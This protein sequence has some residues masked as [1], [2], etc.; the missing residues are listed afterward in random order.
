MSCPAVGECQALLGIPGFA[1]E[2]TGI[3][4]NCWTFCTP[5]V[6]AWLLLWIAGW[7]CGQCE[8]FGSAVPTTTDTSAR[9][10][11]DVSFLASDE[12][13]GRDA[14]IQGTIIDVAGIQVARDFLIQELQDMGAVGIDMSSTDP[15]SYLQVDTS[16]PLTNIIGV[17]VGSD[18]GGL[19]NEYV[20][21]G[22]HYD[23]LRFC[24][25]SAT[26]NS[27]V[28]NGATDNAAGVASILS[29]GRTLQELNPR[30]SILLTLWDAEEDGLIGS[31]F[32]TDD[33]PIVPL[34]SI[35]AYINLDIMGANLVP[36]LRTWSFAIAPETGGAPLERAL[37][38]AIEGEGLTMPSLSSLL[39]QGRSDYIKFENQ[40]VPTVFFSDSNGP[41]YHTT[42]D[43][44]EVV[45]FG[46]V[47]SSMLRSN[48]PQNPDT[49]APDV[50][51][52]TKQT[53]IVTKLA[54]E[55]AMTLNPPSFTSPLL[56][57]TYNDI[58]SLADVVRR[59]VDSGDINLLPTEASRESLRNG[60]SLL[61]GIVARG[62]LLF[63][64]AFLQLD[65]LTAA[66]VTVVNSFPSIV[67][68]GFLSR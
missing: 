49:R 18:T 51:Q 15:D 2:T 25:S 9:L 38:R 47:R 53:R 37:G 44:V 16:F 31:R 36:S 28:C 59:V 62:P 34:D 57:A 66:V 20:V 3:L 14:V 61:E 24:D 50:A 23:H 22:A 63:P 40:N 42:G 67:C 52:L 46:K 48:S 56:P 39:G 29:A 43:E 12:L 41:C 13:L 21:L 10:L 8:D 68:D 45:D 64:L 19:A 33:D 32:F 30:R 11:A 65:E 4:G 6:L 1:L 55:L 54:Y 17:L 5:Q 60:M 7:N 26:A 58:L 35:V 27:D